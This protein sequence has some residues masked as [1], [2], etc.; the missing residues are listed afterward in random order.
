MSVGTYRLKT[1]PDVCVQ[2]I[3]WL[4]NTEEVI[5]FLDD[6]FV[7]HWDVARG[8]AQRIRFRSITTENKHG[9]NTKLEQGDYVIRG[10]NDHIFRCSGD[11]FEHLYAAD[12]TPGISIA[13]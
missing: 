6:A 8:N 5:E 7:L 10:S 12:V 3:Q 13:S 2:A 11:R 9:V 1:H 4:D